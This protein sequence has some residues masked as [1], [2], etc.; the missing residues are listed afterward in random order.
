MIKL[1]HVLIEYFRRAIVAAPEA[2]HG[3]YASTF[4]REF[5]QN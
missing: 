3:L 5:P 1:L 4:T 2:R